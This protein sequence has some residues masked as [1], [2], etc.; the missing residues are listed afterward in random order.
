MADYS[1]MPDYPT[2]PGGASRVY[3]YEAPFRR[4]TGGGAEPLPKHTE[5]VVGYGS[6][7]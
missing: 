3:R 5:I 1:T 7:F 2:K 6:L 4:L